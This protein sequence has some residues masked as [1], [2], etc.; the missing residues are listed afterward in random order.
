[1]GGRLGDQVMAM[2][3]MEKL[4]KGLPLAL[5]GSVWRG[6]PYFYDAFVSHTEELTPVVPKFEPVIGVL[7]RTGCRLKGSF[8]EKDFAALYERY[9]EFRYD[10]KISKE[11]QGGEKHVTG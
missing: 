9:P 11:R 7:I 5:S 2:I 10:L 3:R 4:P 6:N 8:G 1:A